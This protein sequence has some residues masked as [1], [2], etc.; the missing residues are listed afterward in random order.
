[1][2]SKMRRL[3]F[4]ISHALFCLLFKHDNLAKQVLV[5]L[6]VVWFGA[7]YMDLR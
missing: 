5:C 3:S 1:M 7:A 6:S 4:D 2:K